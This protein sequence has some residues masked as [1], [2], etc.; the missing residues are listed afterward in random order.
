MRHPRLHRTAS[1]ASFTLGIVCMALW[2]VSYWRSIGVVAE[3]WTNFY[4]GI[5]CHRGSIALF[6]RHG[7]YVVARFDWF[8]E[9][10]R[11]DPR[12]HQFLNF[13]W[14]SAF[15]TAIGIPLWLCSIVFAYLAIRLL[16]TPKLPTPGLC[17]TCGYD[18][19]ATPD[20]CPECGT[21]A[22]KAPS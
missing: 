14:S 17:S 10:A 18:L 12:I 19:R 9:P 3:L 5:V 7:P 22:A 8:A 2:P 4:A 16:R 20:R 6:W 13:L 1:I 15:V 21:I 11:T